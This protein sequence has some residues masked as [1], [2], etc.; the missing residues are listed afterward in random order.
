[1]RLRTNVTAKS[2]TLN[3]PVVVTLRNG[4]TVTPAAVASRRPC[5]AAV[6]APEFRPV[7]SEYEPPEVVE[8]CTAMVTDVPVKAN[9]WM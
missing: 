3:V 9:R 4:W 1:M 5:G 8:C 2:A 6:S 7:M